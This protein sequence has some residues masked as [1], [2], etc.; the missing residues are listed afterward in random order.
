M[1]FGWNKKRTEKEEHVLSSREI[2]LDQISSILS[3]LKNSKQKHLVEN[4]T[5]LFSNIQDELNS[6]LKIIDHLSNDSLKIDDI[7]NQLKIIVTR[8]KTEVISII[9]KEAKAKMPQ[10]GTLDDV[11]KATELASQALKKIGDVLGKNSRVI[12]VFA[13]KYAQD[14]KDH[15]ATINT[16]YMSALQLL[17]NYTKFESDESLIKEKTDKIVD[18]S[19]TIN[20]KSAQIPKLKT[21]HDHL[22]TSISDLKNKTDSLK[23]SPQHAKYLEI[24]N[25][26]EQN[27][28][29]ENKLHKEID[30]E[31]SKIS[32][33]LGKYFYVTSLEKPLKILMEELIQDPAKTIT[34]QNKGSIIVILESC[35]K[36]TLSGAVSVKEAD[37][38][39]DHI[40]A[41]IR[42]IDDFLVR[43]NELMQK[44]QNLQ[45]QL[46]VFDIDAFEELEQKLQKTITDKNDMESKIKKLESELAQETSN[47]THAISELGRDLQS[48]SNTKYIILV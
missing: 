38:S 41:L 46:G 6:I 27:K 7:D 13:K 47:R 23:S 25:L 16:N 14:L 44:D 37:K 9:S 15:L 31:F 10:L 39:V 45:S 30:E 11:K 3:E 5:P 36:G 24:K 40:S 22:V 35:M 2:K 8:S 28:K 19:Q 12:H 26:I 48:I 18:M 20:D 33:P 42:K 29:E 34:T 17:N 21:T 43:K 32:R 1:V 4:T